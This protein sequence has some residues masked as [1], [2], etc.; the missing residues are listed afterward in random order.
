MNSSIKHKKPNSKS[1]IDFSFSD[2]VDVT[3]LQQLVNNLSELSGLAVAVSDS[4]NNTLVTCGLKKICT[5]FHCVHPATSANCIRSKKYS[6]QHLVKENPI[7]LKCNN[8]L[9]ENLYPIII[10]NKHVASIYL[11]QFLYDDEKIDKKHFTLQAEKYGFDKKEYLNCLKEIPFISHKNEENIKKLTVTLTKML[12]KKGYSNLLLKKQKIDELRKANEELTE[13]EFKFKKLFEQAGVGVSLVEYP[14]GKFVQVNNKFAEMMGYSINEMLKL[15]FL[16]ITHPDDIANSQNSITELEKKLCNEF[17]IEKRYIRKDGTI[18]WTILTISVLNKT[19][20]G[21]VNNIAI[22]Q[23]I[24]SLKKS[25]FLLVE[26][27]NRFSTTMNAMDSVVYV[28]DFENH[29]LLFV[30]KYVENIFGDIRGKKCYTALQGKTTPCDFCTNHL[31]LD[32]NGKINVPHI[33]E[34]QNE[35]TKRWY[36]CHDHAI[37]WTNGK[38]VRFESATDITTNKEIEQKLKEQELLLKELN[39]TKDKFFSIIAHDLKNPFTVLKN[40]TYLLSKHLENGDISKSIEKAKMITNS[41]KNGYSLLENLLLWSKS[42]TGVL[43]IVI[44]DVNLKNRVEAIFNELEN[45]ANLKDISIK[46]EI[47][48]DLLVKAD[49]NLISVVLRNL[50]TNAIKF[51]NNGGKITIIAKANIDNIEIAV[52]DTGIGIPKKNHHRLFKLDDNFSRIGTAKETSSGLG[53]I[54]CKEFVEKHNGK[55]WFESKENKGSIF[56]FTLPFEQ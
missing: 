22:I 10:E 55:I 3:D 37:K 29:E 25:E 5:A 21:I 50:I 56:R 54:L 4:D 9:R 43:K 36:Q 52:I 6:K 2:L 44:E 23:D 51:T 38:I 53:L 31:L 41:V 11:G 34:F 45:H 42:Q 1:V 32:V 48:H 27:N 35:I 14:S 33:W 8:G 18:L 39:A 24:T 26:E 16:Q 28:A 47:S 15:T 19:S 30:N 20:E 12:A 7:S 13:S 40:S 46:N 49:V 17:S